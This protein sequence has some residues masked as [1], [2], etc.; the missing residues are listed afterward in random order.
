MPVAIKVH[1]SY[2]GLISG[3]QGEKVKVKVA[4]GEFQSPWHSPCQNTG[5]GSLPLL[6]RIFPTQGLNPGLPHCKW[7]LYQLSHKG[8]PSILERIAYP[9]SSVSS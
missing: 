5:V 2:L 6:H 9:F 4:H 8:S 1:A 3:S 7:V